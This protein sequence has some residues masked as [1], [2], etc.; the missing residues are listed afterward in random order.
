MTSKKCHAYDNKC[1]VLLLLA[2]PLQHSKL[3][4]TLLVFC[5]VVT[6]EVS[7]QRCS[8]RKQVHAEVASLGVDVL[9]LF[10]LCKTKFVVLNK[11]E[12]LHNFT[13]FFSMYR[14]CDTVL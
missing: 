6:I 1:T 7:M 2:L 3:C 9:L 11:S 13:I 10:F 14:L 8:S 12:N 4:R 5:F